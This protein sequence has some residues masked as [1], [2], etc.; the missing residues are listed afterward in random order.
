MFACACCM[1]TYIPQF[2]GCT[3]SST[4]WNK[5]V[6]YMNDSLKNLNMKTICQLITNQFCA[7]TL[8]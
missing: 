8:K 1:Q 4:L 2:L 7:Q 5:Y 6:R 3:L